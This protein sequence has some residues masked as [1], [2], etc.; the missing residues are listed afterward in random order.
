M[1]LN[2]KR[3]AK[4]GKIEKDEKIAPLHLYTDTRKALQLQ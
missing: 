3:K 2:E 4:K 1:G